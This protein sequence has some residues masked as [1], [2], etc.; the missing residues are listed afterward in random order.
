MTQ[1]EYTVIQRNAPTATDSQA[2]LDEF[3][4]DGWELVAV[5]SVD[6]FDRFY[7]KRQKS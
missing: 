7:L 2:E 3:G 6:N 4:I 1:F 5:S